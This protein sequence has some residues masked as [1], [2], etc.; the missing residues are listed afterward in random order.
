MV[1]MPDRPDTPLTLLG[2]TVEDEHVYRGVLRS[3]GAT[4]Y[5]L[6]E[7]T[8]LPL[9]ELEKRLT[10]LEEAGLVSRADGRV[11]AERPDLV[12]GSFIDTETTRLQRVNA[13][14]DALRTLLPTLMAE[15]VSA[16]E[17]GKETAGLQ[18][19]SGGD[20]VG[21]LR[22]L[23]EETDGELLWLRP[24]QWRLPV[25][26]DVDTLVAELARAGRRSR[27]IYPSRVLEEAPH[28]VRR[29]AR[30]GEQVRLLATLPG[31]LAIFG[32]SAALMPDRWG[33]N[34]GRR[35][36]IREHA[37]VAALRELFE[38]L[39]D[40]AMAVP[41]LES[42]PPDPTGT[43]RLLLG[44][45]AR[46]AKDEQ[47]ARALGLSLRTVRRRIAEIMADLGADSRFQAGVEAVRR[48]WL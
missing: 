29:R 6:T 11:G 45:L 21:L 4:P 33:G 44:Q 36:V 2:L 38:Q 19:V 39:W 32:E 15:Q 5:Q 37:V 8:G 17:A 47:I 12:L 23:V 42:G 25:T 40:E 1:D 10:R 28:V 18:A 3:S 31:R 26:E 46:G 9:G 24:D 22:T 7:V 20:V 16:E 14:I 35:L 34:A 13:Q 48:G 43:R 27:G 30:A 41:G